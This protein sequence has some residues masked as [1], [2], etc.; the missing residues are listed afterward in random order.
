MIPA[1]GDP[2]NNWANI[3]VD[4]DAYYNN[5]IV[6][7]GGK[8]GESNTRLYAYSG[9]N[10]IVAKAAVTI[11]EAEA[12]LTWA[13][14]TSFDPDADYGVNTGEIELAAGDSMGLYFL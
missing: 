14:S 2:F 7:T 11:A 9:Q 5:R 1:A 12:K 6:R 8:E 4:D 3:G 10:V 13:E